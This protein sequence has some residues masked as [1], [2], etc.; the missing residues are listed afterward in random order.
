[1]NILSSFQVLVATSDN[2]LLVISEDGNNGS[3]IED[4]LLQQ[5]ISAPITKMS[6]APN[7]K[8]LACYC[9]DG[10]LTVMSSSFTT[11]VVIHF[12]LAEK[13]V[14]CYPS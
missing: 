12:L 4:Q 2:S 7:G 9:K 10:V 1:M 11:K 6:V 13:A 8:F 14:K 5:K 3:S